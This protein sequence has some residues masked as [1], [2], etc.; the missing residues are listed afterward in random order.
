M[1][2]DKVKPR[3]VRSRLARLDRVWWFL[4]EL[5]RTHWGRKLSNSGK[6]VSS[7]TERCVWMLPFVV[8]TELSVLGSNAEV[9]LFLPCR[10]VEDCTVKPGVAQ[11]LP[12]ISWESSN[13]LGFSQVWRY[14]TTSWYPEQG[15]H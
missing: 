4:L 7:G 15:S 14:H 5:W 11:R 3:S 8:C 12:H 2:K 13:S 6:K 9:N 10:F 1:A